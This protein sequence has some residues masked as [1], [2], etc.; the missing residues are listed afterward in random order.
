M[1]M[2]W[3]AYLRNKIPVQELQLKCRGGLYMKGGVY[4]GCYG[5]N[6]GFETAVS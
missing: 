5:I 3:G 2:V 1:A 6:L 4:V